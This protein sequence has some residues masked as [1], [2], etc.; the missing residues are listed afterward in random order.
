MQAHEKL[1]DCTANDGLAQRVR[2]LRLIPLAALSLFGRQTRVCPRQGV[3]N[4]MHFEM[5]HEY[6][7]RRHQ[8]ITPEINP[9]TAFKP[10]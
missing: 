6:S 7:G 9:A 8:A 2:N 1:G 5:N 10:A 3:Q 4:S